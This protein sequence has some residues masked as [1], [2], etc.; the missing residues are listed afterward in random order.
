MIL[1]LFSQMQEDYK[2][3]VQVRGQDHPLPNIRGRRLLNNSNNS[4]SQHR[5]ASLGDHPHP[6]MIRKTVLISTREMITFSRTLSQ[7]L[8]IKA[9]VNT[10]TTSNSST[11]L[12]KIKWTLSYL[13]CSIYNYNS[14]RQDPNFKVRMITSWTRWTTRWKTWKQRSNFVS[15]R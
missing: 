3:L 2:F 12:R 10:H 14:S 8:H 15:R 1:L 7:Q 13:I 4:H 9:Q 6:N 11:Q 5:S